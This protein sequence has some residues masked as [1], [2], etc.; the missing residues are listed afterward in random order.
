MDIEYLEP[1]V[2]ASDETA[3]PLLAGAVGSGRDDDGQEDSDKLGG[4]EA[5]PLLQ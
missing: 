4:R 5:I 1:S 2:A 3:E